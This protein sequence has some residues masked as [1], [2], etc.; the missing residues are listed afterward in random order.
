MDCH[1]LKDGEKGSK[2]S[3]FRYKNSDCTDCH[4][5]IHGD[6]FVVEGKTHCKNCHDNNSWRPVL[7][8]HDQTAFK[9]D[10]KH[11]NLECQACHKRDQGYPDRPIVYK[12]KNYQ[13]ADCHH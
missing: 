11:R 1:K 10:G 5:N 9:L 8:D 7:F 2:Y 4:L 6:Q 3:K 12:L 13:C